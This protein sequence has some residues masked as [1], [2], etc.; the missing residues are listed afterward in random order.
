MDPNATVEAV[1]KAQGTSP[2]WWIVGG[3]ALLAIGFFAVPPLL[4]KYSNKLYKSSAKKDHVDIES[5]G[6]EI[7]RIDRNEKKGE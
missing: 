7:V 5:L 3:V 4:K 1:Q 2:I 6:P